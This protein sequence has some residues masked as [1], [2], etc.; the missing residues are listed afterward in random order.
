MERRVNGVTSIRRDSL[1]QRDER[2]ACRPYTW[3]TLGTEAVQGH[4]ELQAWGH[5][6]MRRPVALTTEERLPMVDGAHYVYEKK[7]STI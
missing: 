5:V 4:E 2:D 1:L 6:W 3:I 7:K